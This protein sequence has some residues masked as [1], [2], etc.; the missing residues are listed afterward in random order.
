M[1]SETAFRMV[2]EIVRENREPG[3]T[4]E[5]VLNRQRVAALNRILLLAQPEFLCRRRGKQLV[6]YQRR[7]SG[8]SGVSKYTRMACLRL[9]QRL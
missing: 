3:N 5:G 4:F 1:K 8:T 9:L 7:P 2:Q 6:V